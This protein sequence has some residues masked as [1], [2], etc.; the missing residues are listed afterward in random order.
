LATTSSLKVGGVTGLATATA[1]TRTKRQR[2]EGSDGAC[3]VCSVRTIYG[4]IVTTLNDIGERRGFWWWA[5]A[6]LTP[7]GFVGGPLAIADI[8]AGLIHW[9]GWLGYLV[10]YWDEYVSEPFRLILTY[11]ANGLSL[12]RP[13]EL[14]VDY[15]A[16]GV[17]LVAGFL[18]ALVLIEPPNGAPQ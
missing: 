11:I 4:A 7:V 13:P 12:P 10:H 3:G 5:T 17:L 2:L 15:V 1:P 9:N 16:L 8:L 14:L 18:R 6:I